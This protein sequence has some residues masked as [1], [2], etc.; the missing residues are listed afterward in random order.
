[1]AKKQ[2]ALRY[3]LLMGSREVETKSH[4]ELEVGGRYWGE[5]KT[6]TGGV[7]NL[8]NL[9]KKPSFLQKN[10][11]FKLDGETVLK[12]LTK[13]GGIENLKNQLLKRA[14][15]SES[16]N[17][18]KFYTN[19]ALKLDEGK[20]SLPILYADKEFFLQLQEKKRPARE[21][22]NQPLKQKSVQF[23]A[24]FN[25]LGPIEGTVYLQENQK[26]L[27]LGV[28]YA[29]TLELLKSQ[30]EQLDMETLFSIKRE[31]EPLFEMD[32]KLLDISV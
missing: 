7:I 23:Y 30:S 15:E 19:M 14:G 13:E 22:D 21:K 3:T 20:I 6:G 2:D 25:N 8:S 26:T 18:F 12:E 4:K 29:S 1:V 17:E 16:A 31:I 9:K 27:H 5:V 32:E 24:V 28:L 10:F 11:N